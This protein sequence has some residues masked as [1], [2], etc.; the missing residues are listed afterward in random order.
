LVIIANSHELGSGYLGPLFYCKK[1][2]AM[3]SH[4]IDMGALILR[5]LAEKDLTVAWLARRIDYDES[6]LRK[7]LKQN[8][9]IHPDLLFN[10]A[11]EM[12]ED[13][14]ACYSQRLKEVKSKK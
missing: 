14:F 5:K 1:I 11:D 4:G 13:F 7:M 2:G 3:Y 9:V 12:D 10:I 8:R 6:N